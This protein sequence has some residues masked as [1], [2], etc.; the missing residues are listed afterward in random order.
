[1]YIMIV[2]YLYPESVPVQGSKI[3]YFS[4]PEINKTTVLNMKK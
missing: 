1:M 4:A 2:Y 3:M